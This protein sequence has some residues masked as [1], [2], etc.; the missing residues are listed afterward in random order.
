VGLGAGVLGFTMAKVIG[1][2]LPDFYFGLF[3]FYVQ[4]MHLLNGFLDGASARFN[5]PD[6]A[7]FLIKYRRP[8]IAC[9]LCSLVMSL[10]AAALAGFG[11][12]ALILGLSILGLAYAVPLPFLSKRYQDI[13]RLKDLPLSKTLSVALG[14]ATLLAWPSFFN[15]PALIPRTVTG[16][17]TVF[18][19]GIFVFLNV[20]CRTILM[21]VEDSQG[22]RHFG[23]SSPV[24][25]MGFTWTVRFFKILLALWSLYL[26]GLWYFEGF[27]TLWLLFLASGPLY[28]GLLLLKLLR[29]PS[30]G[31]FQSDLLL[32]G[33]FF[34][35]GLLIWLWI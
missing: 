14:W 17:K 22:D 3:F 35:S 5:D 33:Q 19:V 4:A 26:I 18:I 15:S 31:G 28:N 27:K 30:L 7:F 25:L 21:D 24:G 9:G 8:L 13:R 16:L 23:Q 12:L 6:R 34:L 32:D 29:R 20:L 11:V 1:Y 2:R 10:T